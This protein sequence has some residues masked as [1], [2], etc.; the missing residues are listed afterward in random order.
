[1]EKRF[2][3]L[4]KNIK[5]QINEQLPDMDKEEQEGFFYNLNEWSYEQYEKSMSE[6]ECEMQNYEEE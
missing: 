2:E 3:E 4:L 1:M 5:E 6:D